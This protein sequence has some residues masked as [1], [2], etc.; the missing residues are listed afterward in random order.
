M[1]T[2][3]EF[4]QFF[5]S[6][7]ACEHPIRKYKNFKGTAKEAYETLSYDHLRFVFAGV[8]TATEEND[9]WDML[10]ELQGDSVWNNTTWIYNYPKAVLPT[11]KEQAEFLRAMFPFEEI[12]AL[13]EA[14]QEGGWFEEA[15]WG[16]TTVHQPA[17][18]VNPYA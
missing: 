12:A 9:L 15:A 3:K 10:Y 14:R 17:S 6:R 4:A 7:G 13:I 8:F 16:G 2:S 18:A 11:K 5:K 1:K